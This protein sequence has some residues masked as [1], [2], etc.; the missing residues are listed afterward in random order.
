[1]PSVACIS[2]SPRR[3]GNTH[4]CAD[5][6]ASTLRAAGAGVE[7]FNLVDHTI[8][9]CAGCRECMRLMRCA[10][11]DD[12]F[13]PIMDAVLDAD[14]LALA[15]PVYWNGP[16]GIMKDFIDR[17]HGYYACSGVLDGTSAYL[18]S[19][20]TAS[21]FETH[22]DIMGSWLT[23]Y[24][25]TVKGRLRVRAR[26]KDDVRNDPARRAEVEAFARKMLDS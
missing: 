10:I 22:E 2:G 16:P 20:A 12:E 9:R 8:K 1:M 7:H 17:T 14:I 13:Q 3:N 18:L 26:E 23:A 4:F 11:Q 15:A 19:V 24:G 5:L 25:A 21:G 6:V